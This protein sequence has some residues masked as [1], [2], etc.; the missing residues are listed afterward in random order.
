MHLSGVLVLCQPSSI[1]ACLRDL[2]QR[3]NI[4]VY[5]TDRV[6]GRIV[7]VMETETLDEQAD[8]LR[9]VQRLPNVTAAELVYH[10][11][12]DVEDMP[13]DPTTWIDREENHQSDSKKSLE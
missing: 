12:G 6:A 3:S 13:A 4:D 8:E 5:V 2:A 1:E 11:F 9:S 10:Y 7:V